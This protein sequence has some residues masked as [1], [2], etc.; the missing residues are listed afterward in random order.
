MARYQ[1]IA[2]GRQWNCDAVDAEWAKRLF[3]VNVGELD[4]AALATL[5]DID[6]YKPTLKAKT[7][8]KVRR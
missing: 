6:D 4:D 7:A 8:K 1:I 3:E 2:R 5:I